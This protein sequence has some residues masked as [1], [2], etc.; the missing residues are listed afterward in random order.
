[1]QLQYQGFNLEGYLKMMG[2]EESKIRADYRDNAL[3]D[4]KTQLVVEKIA[5]TENIEVTPEEFDAELAKMAET[6]KQPVEEMKKHLHED[7][8]EYIKNSI[9]RRKTVAMLVENVKA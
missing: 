2:M 3:R 5:E 7:D 9:E 8:I 1:M 4:V 6:Y